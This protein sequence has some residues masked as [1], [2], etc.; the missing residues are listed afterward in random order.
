MADRQKRGKSAQQGVT[1]PAPAKGGARHEFL[2]DLS[3]ALA[4]LCE[5]S[6]RMRQRLD[7]IDPYEQPSRWAA[8][9]DQIRGLDERI[10]LLRDDHQRLALVASELRALVPGEI[11]QLRMC[12]AALS[13]LVRAMG[14]STA[15]AEAAGK[16]AAVAGELVQKTLPKG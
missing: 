11:A 13:D 3:Q 14:T 10:S 5:A 1:H 15:V 7:Q 6:E 12:T 16:L 4:R 2:D 8:I 9:N